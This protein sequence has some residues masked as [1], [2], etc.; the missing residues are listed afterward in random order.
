M[1]C[2]NK[3]P[4][5]FAAQ[6]G[7]RKPIEVAYRAPLVREMLLVQLDVSLEHGV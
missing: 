1:R 4:F 3:H 5:E 6:F 2:C 7:A